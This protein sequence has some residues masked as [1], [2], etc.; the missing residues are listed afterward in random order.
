MKCTLKINCQ[1]RDSHDGHPLDAAEILVANTYGLGSTLYV[2]AAVCPACAGMLDQFDMST[3]MMGPVRLIGDRQNHHGCYPGSEKRLTLPNCVDCGDDIRTNEV[4]GGR[5]HE[6]CKECLNAHRIAAATAAQTAAAEV[7]TQTL[8]KITVNQT[9]MLSR[10]VLAFQSNTEA[11][12]AIRKQIRRN[13]NLTMKNDTPAAQPPTSG[14]L[15]RVSSMA[16]DI[17]VD[18]MAVRAVARQ[19]LKLVKEPV[20]AALAARSDTSQFVGTAK[21]FLGTEFGDA[22]LSLVMSAAV[23]YIPVVPQAWREPLAREFVVEG[24]A[25]VLDTLADVFAAPIRNAF[26]NAAGTLANPNI[27]PPRSSA[28]PFDVKPVVESDTVAVP[29]SNNPR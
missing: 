2:F 15:D 7:Q 28:T 23:R 10:L 24:G 17:G 11:M 18:D 6:R 16:A 29:A 25:S 20:I 27:F 5:Y 12:V 8:A 26:S 4:I 3:H 13:R 19:M 14:F 9:E 22:A 21:A 1:C